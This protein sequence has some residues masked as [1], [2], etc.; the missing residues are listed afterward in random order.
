MPKSIANSAPSRKHGVAANTI[1]IL[2]C[3]GDSFAAKTHRRAADGS[4]FTDSFNSGMYFDHE[5]VPFDDLHGLLRVVSEAAANPKK[6]II[7]GRLRT[8]APQ[9]GDGRVRRCNRRQADGEEPY[10]EDADR[11]WV[12]IDFDK[13]E[14]PN[15]LDP[16]SVEG[17]V[18]LRSLLPP[19]F[20]D[21]ECVYSLSAS[22]GLSGSGRISG[23]LWFVLDR[24]VSNRELK[25]WFQE[26]PVDP[27]LFQSVQPHYIGS[28][29]FKDGL[30]DPIEIDRN[31][32]LP[33]RTDVVAVPE[34]DTSRPAYEY[35]GKGR[36]IEA[37]HGYEAKMALLGDGDGKE[38]C[39]GVITPAIASYMTR[40]G[41]QADRE[42]LKADIRQ[43]VADAPW[44]RG[45][46]SE[47]YVSNEVSD[48]TLDRS[49]QDWVDKAF[50]QADGYSLSE[51]D[52]VEVAREKVELAVDRYVTA[53]TRWQG[54]HDCR[55]ELIKDGS[56]GFFKIDKQY[57][58]DLSPPPRYGLAAQVA[59]GKTEAYISRVH[60]L[61]PFLRK[62]HCI[63]IGVPNHSLS[64]EL[65]QRLREHG[66]E[67]EVYLGP[68]QPDPNQPGRKMCWVSDWLE[69]FQKTDSG[70]TLCKVC[71]H[72]EECGFKKQRSKKSLVWIGAHQL[73]YRKRRPPIPPIDFVIIDEDPLPAGLEGADPRNPK[74]LSCEEV[75]ADVRKVIE[76]LPPCLP[77]SR[78]DLA[79]SD[80]RLHEQV[81][82]TFAQIRKVELSS[83]ASE[84]EIRD[85]V[86]VTQANSRLI[87]ITR[88]YRAI[89]DNGPWGMR[90]YQL[91]NG[92][93]GLRWIHHRK[94][95]SDFDVPTLFADATLN[96][97]AIEHIID[98]ERPPADV[99]EAWVD[100]DGSI[101]PA[102]DQRQP[103]IMGPAVKVSAKTPHANFRQVLFSGAAAQF[104]GDGVGANNVARVRRYIEAR[105]SSFGEVLVICQ[106]ELEEKL[107]ALGL[108]PNV[109]IAHFNA[110][111]GQDKWKDV[112]LLIVIGRTQPSPPDVELQA[113]ALF[114][115]P[116]KTLGP[117]YYDTVWMPLTDMAVE[118]GTERHPDKHADIIRWQV[119]EAEIIQAIGR[120]RAVNRTVENPV[121]IDIINMVPLPGIEIDEVVEWDDAQPD[122]GAVI[123]G[124]YGV[125]LA[126]ESAKGT[127]NVVAA[128]LPDLFGTVNAAKQAKVY[129]RAKTPNKKYLLG[130][131]ARE[132]TKGPE[133]TS[134]PPI[135]LNAPGCRFAVLAYSLRPPTR[136]PLLKGEKPP[137]G[138]DVDNEGVLSYGPVYVLKNIPRRL[139]GK[140]TGP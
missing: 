108:P 76:Q 137:K 101:V 75:P 45:K 9:R 68:A 93:T 36:G 15:G 86:A 92:A 16:A 69:I 80:R 114:L 136:R 103:F 8:D 23:H 98:V 70:G 132:Y 138:A 19:E 66:I 21:V 116:I 102:M 83:N 14:N 91:K 90:P 130:V 4:L 7:R 139:K 39:H 107:T 56:L 58:Y 94:I 96:A 120:V 126:D 12:M 95:H 6:L 17:M 72:W 37:A 88:F 129:S 127:A 49:I 13:V 110:I 26:Y 131:L 118:V 48:E 135:A 84:K 27:R 32:L 55:Q 47:E 61:L 31:A 125:L 29:I 59:L 117:E 5:E 105:A 2:T 3:T 10:F 112:D 140:I 81:R 54:Q 74:Y 128:L 63:F 52:D 50:V 24:P 67:A 113:E 42:A 73:L 78:D 100:E 46:H 123:A 119:C 133:P 51:L 57:V 1:T 122:P 121:Q 53:A 99:E 41:P 109:L 134:A 38:G 11:A 77:F 20:H 28:P 60:L 115:T 79:I 106:M 44:D 22:A 35:R 85:A 97:D 30:V 71:P 87:E 40:H 62:G 64:E 111:R 34:I 124:R 65:I 25:T 43:R 33:G 89:A 18:H 104:K 82:R